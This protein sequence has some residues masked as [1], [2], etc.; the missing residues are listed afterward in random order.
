MRRI[1]LVCLELEGF[2]SF[3]RR[4]LI[5]FSRGAGLKH[6][7]GENHAE[8]ALGANGAGKSTLWDALTYCWYGTSVRGLKASNLLSWGGD[9]IWVETALEIDGKLTTILRQGSP[10]RLSIDGNTATQIDVDR[11]I[12]LTKDQLLQSVVFG[13]GVP[14]FVDLP[15]PERGLLLDQVLD[16]SVWLKAT[17]TA[18]RHHGNLSKALAQ[19][20]RDLAFFQGKLEGMESAELI[21]AAIDLWQRD[22]DRRVEQAIAA[23][24][25]SES[26]LAEMK[27]K[28]RATK[29]AYEVLPS[30]V[31][32]SKQ[33]K[34]LET[35]RARF[36]AT[37][38]T[39]FDRLTNTQN[40]VRFYQH[41][42]ACPECAQAIPR[43]H[44]H[45]RIRKL[46]TEKI[47]IEVEIKSNTMQQRMV[48]EQ[49]QNLE[50]DVNKLA[51]KR[52]FLMDQ[53]SRAVGDYAAQERIVDGAVTAAETMFEAVN[54]HIV[55]RDG[56]ER[57]R[58]M[59]ET[60]IASGRIVQRTTQAGL[61]QTDFWRAAFKRVRL[62]LVKRVLAQLQIETMAA[63]AA[64]GLTD[65]SITF[66]TELE[67]KSGGLRPGIH[68]IIAAPGGT[69]APWEVYSGGE[70]QRI[71]L[72]VA[73]GLASLIQR[74]AGVMIMTEVWDEPG[75]WLS[76]EGVEHLVEYL[77]H[78][79]LTTGKSL[80]VSAHGGIQF[81]SF[82]E[83]HC[84]YKDSTGSH[85]TLLSSQN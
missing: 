22:Q 52:E 57:E 56:L 68:V 44:A 21:Q 10:D 35:S 15:G 71:R 39:L 45:T 58:E 67:T 29:A 65:W 5:E 26:M 28:V 12:G 47:D 30:P 48:S 40:Q 17:D 80:W 76:Q 51:R 77:K 19:T 31:A 27:R 55:R 49:L 20:E 83:V 38:K 4:T 16:L 74:M 1:Q 79:V 78:R 13:Q 59:V 42:N 70:G 69:P 18:T 6:L 8:P 25:E 24:E 54:P 33:L 85:L 64:L 73:L 11:L 72:A 9:K 62:F 23:V 84:V 14:L 36:D 7:T 81:S 41:N 32:M 46:T 3:R 63:A 82:Q 53:R 34:G 37:Y 61:L 2:R 75:A 60:N 43:P 66:A 50:D